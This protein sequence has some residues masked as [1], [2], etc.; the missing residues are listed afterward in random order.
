MR[1]DLDR[2]RRRRGHPWR[3]QVRLGVA[4]HAALF[5]GGGERGR[6]RKVF[7]CCRR[8]RGKVY[9]KGKCDCVRKTGHGRAF[10]LKLRTVLLKLLHFIYIYSL[11][12]ILFFFTTACLSLLLLIIFILLLLGYRTVRSVRINTGTYRIIPYGINYQYPRG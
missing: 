11:G 6:R 12:S 3:V 8:C 5:T 4:V 2:G 9:S 1:A 7:F 10:V